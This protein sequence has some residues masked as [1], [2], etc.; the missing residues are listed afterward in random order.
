MKAV[1]A[2]KTTSSKPP[3]RVKVLAPRKDAKG[4]RRPG[5]GGCDDEFGCTGNHNEV[6]VEARP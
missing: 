5:G 1:S 6:S 2:K 3:L 4:G